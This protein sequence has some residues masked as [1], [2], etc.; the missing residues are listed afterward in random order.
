MTLTETVCDYVNW[1]KTESDGKDVVMMN[2]TS[3]IKAGSS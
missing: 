3:S 2:P 1:L